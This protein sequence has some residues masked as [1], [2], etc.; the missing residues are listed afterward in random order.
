M[1]TSNSKNYS[2]TRANIIEASLRKIG[3]Y[4]QGEA[5]SGSETA[6]A[7]FALN[8]MVKEWTARGADLWLRDEITLFLQ[9]DTKS[10]S[11]GTANATAS[12]VETTLSAAAGATATVIGVTSSAGMAVADLIGV[13]LIDNSIHWDTIASVDSSVQVT[14]TTGLA[15]A[16]ASSGRVYAYTTTAG[17]PT[18]VLYAY[19]R[20]SSNIDVPVDLI[21]EKEYMSQSNKSSNGPPVEA[22]YHP[23]L[24]TGTLYV[25]PI[26][27][28]ATL[29]KLVLSCQ[30]YADDFDS[31]SNNP[32][33]PPEW[34]NAL[35]WG[36]AA[37]LASEYGVT[38]R[39]QSRLWSTAE[40]KLN[41]ALDFD[42]EN[43]SVEFTL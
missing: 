3:A 19:R 26:D 35:V 8:V 23:T 29:D 12:Y 38:E 24:T 33:F 17:R 15:S 9:P 25:W 6:A 43:S 34:Y 13:K 37:E 32:Q 42:V 5:V 10:Y 30:F 28:G 40:F 18:K 16:A 22:W 41:N 21:G 4:D 1:A 7:D 14:I 2:V 11:L 36:L 31:A 27:G 39:E 20:D